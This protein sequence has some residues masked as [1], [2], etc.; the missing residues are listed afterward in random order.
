MNAVT[1]PPL[2]TL[3]PNADRSHGSIQSLVTFRNSQ[4]IEARGTLLRLTRTSLVFEVYNPYSIVQ[5]SEVLRA[6]RIR[7]GSRIVYDGRAVVTNLLNTGLLLI[8]SVKLIDPWTDLQGL[9][10]SG[11]GMRDEASRF[12]SDWKGTYQLK[13]GYQLA[14]TH[15][16][17]FLGELSRWMEQLDLSQPP[18]ATSQSDSDNDFFEELTLPLREQMVS[19]LWEFEENAD[20][21][22]EDELDLH[23]AFTQR[24]LHPLMLTAPFVHR[25]FTKPLGYAGDYD[26]INMIYRNQ[27]EGRTAYAR[28]VH[29]L[30]TRIPIAQSV[31][32][33]NDTLLRYLSEAAP[34]AHLESRAL[35]VLSIG[36]GPAWE[37]QRFIRLDP[38]AAR[39]H[40]RL[41]DFNQETLEYAKSQVQRAMD[42]TRVRPQVDF[43][44]ESVHQLLKQAATTRQED[45]E[46]TFDLIYCAGLFDYLS[47][48][49]CARLLR[50][51]Y[52]WLRPGGVALA[53]NMHSSANFR[54]CME[55][56]ADWN[57]IY[58]DETRME[59]LCPEEGEHQMFTDSTGINLC[60]ELRK[61]AKSHH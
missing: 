4:G 47:D 40:F 19:L 28:L 50:L 10:F 49:V 24:D 44:H 36:C 42:E 34:L 55:H 57:L 51:F 7:R 53:T 9:S 14:V 58:R 20:N 41:V 23:K 45:V 16:R 17:S 37:V 38:D 56:I 31:R 61:T 22:S 39:F 13:P 30:F 11:S 18:D 3:K 52:F 59:A 12:V 29:S 60:L 6:L 27:P 15:L 1:A 8:V 25:T 35:S 5:L 32:N 33:R 26:M 54:A 46:P 48:R 2:P 43:V 21:L